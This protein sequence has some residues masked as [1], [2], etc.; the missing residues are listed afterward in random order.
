MSR[1]PDIHDIS[2]CNVTGDFESNLHKCDGVTRSRN[3]TTRR[4]SSMRPRKGIYMTREKL[5]EFYPKFEHI[6]DEGVLSKSFEMYLK[7][8]KKEEKSEEQYKIFLQHKE[9]F[10]ICKRHSN[11]KIPFLFLSEMSDAKHQW[12]STGTLSKNLNF[13]LTTFKQM[14]KENNDIVIQV[15][16]ESLQ[17]T[18]LKGSKNEDMDFSQQ[19]QQKLKK[20]QTKNNELESLL[21]DYLKGM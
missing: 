5:T 9:M 14:L 7:L 4:C 16:Q 12:F 13:D 18:N 20:L 3:G 21:S 15:I 1:S 2:F 17:N 19:I 11:R 6:V 8:N 10:Y